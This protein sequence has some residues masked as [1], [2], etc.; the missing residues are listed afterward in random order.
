MNMIDRYILKQFLTTLIFAIVALCVIFLVVNLMENLDDFIDQNAKLSIIAQYY[1]SFFPEILKILTPVAVLISTLF[2][3]GRLSSS[4]EL[5]AMKTGG[6][7][8]Y[9]LMIPLIV[10]SLALS[11]GQLYFNGWIVPQ[12][13]QKKIEIEQVYLNKSKAKAGTLFN[14][15]FRDTP[16]RNVMMQYYQSNERSGYQVG[17]EDYSS[18]TS[19]RLTSRI[20]AERITWHQNHWLLIKGIKRKYNNG[21]VTTSRFDTLSISLNI[22]HQQLVK[23]KMLPE[24]M[25]FDE[26]KDYLKV[27]EMGG[28]DTRQDKIDYYAGFAFPFANFIVILF[29]VPFA[30]VK[31]KGGIAI[32][33]GAAMVIVFAYLIFTEVSKTIGYANNLDPI[34][35]AWSANVIF[36]FVGIV[37]LIKT[38]T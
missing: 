21:E 3:I 37:V 16:A 14:L 4:N 31:Q 24:E 28:K 15:F 19:P 6:M 38:K 2:T 10:F 27:L 33:I 1:L 29:G 25:N 32:Q 26:M 8:I 35:T 34:L 17:I 5:T 20:E 9:R 13:N 11:L 12:A 30:S 23:L 7:S 18:E 36:F 22:R